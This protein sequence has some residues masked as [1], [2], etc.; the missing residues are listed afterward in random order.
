MKPFK[1][2]FIIENNP[3]LVL[4]VLKALRNDPELSKTFEGSIKNGIISGS[5]SMLAL[6]NGMVIGYFIVD[7][8][9]SK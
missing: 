2:S 8:V 9:Y 1:I 4:S 7:G 3:E 5:Y 6:I